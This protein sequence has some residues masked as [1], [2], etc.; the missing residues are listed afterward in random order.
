MLLNLLSASVFLF[1][2]CR[3]V[4]RDFNRFPPERIS[5]LSVPTRPLSMT[6]DDRVDEV[7]VDGNR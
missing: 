6:L 2:F 5:L 1:A 7:I 3:R 4:R